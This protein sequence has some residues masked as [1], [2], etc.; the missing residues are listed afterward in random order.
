L[1]HAQLDATRW[2]SMYIFG[3]QLFAAH[4]LALEAIDAAA[5]AKGGLAGQPAGVVSSKSLGGASISYDNNL[6]TEEGAGF[7]NRTLYGRQLWRWIRMAGMG[8]VQIFGGGMPLPGPYGYG[9]G[10]WGA[11]GM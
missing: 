10:R 4:Y 7:W 5:V 3:Q 8:G 11:G 9:R 6:G 1:A 2:G